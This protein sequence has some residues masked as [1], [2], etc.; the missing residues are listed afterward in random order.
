MT[1]VLRVPGNPSSALAA[2]RSEV[3]AVDKDLALTDVV[4]LSDLV[5]ESTSDERFR[6]ILLSGFAGVALFLAA[7]GIYGVLAY[8]VTQRMRE[9]GIRLALGAQG[10]AIFR[11]VVG[12]GMRPVAIGGAAGI[13]GAFAAGR[14]VKALLFGVEALDP[15]VYSSAIGVLALAAFLASALPALRA[16]RVDPLVVLR[17]E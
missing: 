17:E 15:F 1:F 3:H 2:A 10:A 5:H 13:A 14:L 4:T 16:T 6:T 8:W 12:E 11:T 9:L 7:L